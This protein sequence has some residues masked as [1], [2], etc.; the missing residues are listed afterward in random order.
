M[1]AIDTWVILCYI[2]M[3]SAIMEY[4]LI[5]YL[6]KN[7]PKSNTKTGNQTYKSAHQPEETQALGQ[8][9]AHD[10]SREKREK[11]SN[12]IE[13]FAQIILPSYTILFP[14]VYFIICTS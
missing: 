9:E 7:V 2:G 14:M 11:I 12:A 13:K 5:L 8:S 3:F 1:R 6:T 4:V 10:Q